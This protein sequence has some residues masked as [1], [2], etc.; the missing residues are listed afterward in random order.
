[1]NNK[2]RIIKEIS[3]ISLRISKL[4]S[5]LN[6]LTIKTN[7]NNENKKR[8]SKKLYK[9]VVMPIESWSL[10]GLPNVFR[11]KYFPLKIVWTIIFLASVGISIYFLYNTIKEYL[12]Y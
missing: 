4:K 3:K 8:L 2:R 12:K 7:R 10:H 9:E 1:M 6:P 5:Q 11:T